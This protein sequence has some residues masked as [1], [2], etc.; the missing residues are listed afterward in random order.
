SFAL[1]RRASILYSSCFF[2]NICL[3]PRQ[4]SGFA[5]PNAC[6]SVIH[7][8]FNP[9]LRSSPVVAIGKIHSPHE[10]IENVVADCH[11]TKVLDYFVEF[12]A[13]KTIHRNNCKNN[14]QIKHR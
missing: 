10:I 4:R 2:S 13:T 11:I 9:K 7:N 14:K 3:A 6:Y 1:C 8:K 12:G 5:Q